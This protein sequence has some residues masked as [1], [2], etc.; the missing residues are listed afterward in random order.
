[1]I[2]TVTS[3]PAAPT[4]TPVAVPTDTPLPAPTANTAEEP[5]AGDAAPTIAPA[6]GDQPAGDAAGAAAAPLSLSFTAADWHGGFHR[7][8]AGFLGRPWTALY[9]AQSGYDSAALRFTLE[10]APTGQ[11]HLAIT[12]LDDENGGDSPISIAVNGVEVF[13]GPSPFPNWDGNAANASWAAVD[14]AFPADLLQPG[15]NEIT[16]TNV[17]DSAAVGVPPYVLLADATLTA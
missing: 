13:S 5:A 12:G 7:D 15:D 3:E 9:G 8:N 16:V 2:V 11:V 1:V 10:V 17:V 6:G 14:V 4:D